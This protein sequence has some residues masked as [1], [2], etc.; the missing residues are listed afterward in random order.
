[1]FLKLHTDLATAPS[2]VSPYD[3]VLIHNPNDLKSAVV[4]RDPAFGI[5]DCPPGTEMNTI[6]K[7][8]A[9]FAALSGEYQQRKE[10][11][12]SAVSEWKWA[13]GIWF[14]VRPLYF[15]RNG[16]SRGRQLR[17]K[18]SKSDGCVSCGLDQLGRVT[19][20]RYGSDFGF[21]ETFFKWSPNSVEVA[22]YAQ[23]EKKPTG[24]LVA[25]LDADRVVESDM[26]A[27]SGFFH[28]EYEW[29]DSVVKQ[30]R[31]HYSQ[32]VEGQLSPLQL[33]HTAN[34]HYD[35]KN[36]LQR[37]ELVWPI[38]PPERVEEVVE[39]VFKRR[40]KKEKLDLQKDFDEM[41]S[42]L[43]ERVQRFDSATNQGP[44]DRDHITLIN[45]GY[46]CDQA[47]WIALIFDTRP[48]AKPDG[49]WTMHI[50]RN[51]FSRPHWRRITQALENDSV[52]VVLPDGTRAKLPRGAFDEFYLLLG[53]MLKAVLLKA[54]AEGVFTLLPKAAEC[55][56]A[57]EE[58]G[59]HYGWPA[60][61]NRGNEDL[62]VS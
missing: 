27:I 1:M 19:V 4:S 50:E 30:V 29:G 57:V 61:E 62:V 60:Y 16:L 38:M 17:N 8:E 14:D 51:E 55:H 56:I 48:D 32:R 39:L 11:A 18:P 15:E 36:A 47:G 26:S 5:L 43:V 23:S 58:I 21:R 6:A 34:A 28:E 44:G 22:H 2:S 20:E 46:Q 10:Q 25:K 59:G 54:R 9:G 41:Y 12:E 52:A 37:V 33:W 24:L 35:E 42:H 53:E 31:F 40:R 7:V 45:I 3:R 49:E 13:T